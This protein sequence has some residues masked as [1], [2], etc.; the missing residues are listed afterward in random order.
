MNKKTFE[1]FLKFRDTKLSEANI[2][3]NRIFSNQIAK[4]IW[5]AQ[6]TSITELAKIPGMPA[7]GER[8]K[9]YGTAIIAFIN[10]SQLFQ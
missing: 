3:G 1:D 5:D 10:G 8:I 9:K 4:A 6:P 2:K 7:N